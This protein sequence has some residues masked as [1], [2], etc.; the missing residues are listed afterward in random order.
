MLLCFQRFDQLAALRGLAASV[1]ACKERC[2][3]R[4]T[5]ITIIN[6]D[7]PSKRIN[8]PRVVDM[9]RDANARLNRVNVCDD[10][11]NDASPGGRRCCRRV[12]ATACFGALTISNCTVA[13]CRI[14]A[15]LQ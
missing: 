2:V 10:E 7:T 4:R 15:V 1:D 12:H 9:E 5:I 14:D 11:F 6:P 13:A 8:A 3:G